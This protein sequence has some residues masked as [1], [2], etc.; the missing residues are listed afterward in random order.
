MTTEVACEEEVDVEEIVEVPSGCLGLLVNA[1]DMD[2]VFVR[3]N[4][5]KDWTVLVQM[6]DD[7][8]IRVHLRGVVPG[9]IFVVDIPCQNRE[10]TDQPQSLDIPGVETLPAEIP[11]ALLS[12]EPVVPQADSDGLIWYD[13]GYLAGPVLDEGLSES[14]VSRN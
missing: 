2:C 8:N 9:K 5:H 12:D 7:G 11:S 14:I 10:A 13:T 3:Q 1:T 4:R 6:A